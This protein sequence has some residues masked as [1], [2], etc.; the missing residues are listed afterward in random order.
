MKDQRHIGIYLPAYKVLCCLFLFF[1]R[2]GQS[3]E[4]IYV[5]KFSAASNAFPDN[6]IT[7]FRRYSIHELLILRIL[8]LSGSIATS[9]LL[10]LATFFRKYLVMVLE[11]LLIFPINLLIR[12][13]ISPVSS[14]S[15]AAENALN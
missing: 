11:Y 12:T 7:V 14:N 5:Y 4:L 6:N 13:N 9:R 15:L 10:T 1:R 3:Q 2:F 8:I